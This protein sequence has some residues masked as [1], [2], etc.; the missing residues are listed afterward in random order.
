MATSAVNVGSSATEIV[1]RNDKRIHLEI[2]NDG[3]STIYI[4]SDNSVTS[5]TGIPLFSG[6]RRTFEA[7]TGEYR[8]YYRGAIFGITASGTNAVRVLELLEVR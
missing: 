4:G 8:F 7:V 2:Y 3:G 1:D 6:Q 5:S